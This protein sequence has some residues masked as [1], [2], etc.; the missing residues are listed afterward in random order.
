M[1]VL[2]L[3]GVFV[4]ACANKQSIL[5]FVACLGI[6]ACGSSPDESG[7]TVAD[8]A[9][10]ARVWSGPFE[11]RE[12]AAAGTA[13]LERDT[14]GAHRLIFNNGFEI[15]NGP[16]LFAYI[17][18]KTIADVTAENALEGATKLTALVAA[19]GDQEYPVAAVAD[20]FAGTAFVWCETYGVLF[21]A[22]GLTAK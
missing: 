20:D 3:R 8:N 14:A 4:S 7:V 11:A 10:A 13:R 19:K 9:A 12:H 1:T 6:S 21:G 5:V 17:S 16:D 2:S 15:D 18:P 22:A